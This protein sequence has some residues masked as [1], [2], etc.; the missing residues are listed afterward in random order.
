MSY[1]K[2]KSTKRFNFEISRNDTSHQAG[3]NEVTISTNPSSDRYSTGISTM[4]MT[5]KE[6]RALNLFLTNEL[7]QPSTGDMDFS[8]PNDSIVVS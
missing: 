7:A 5:V 1:T 8:D 4:R 2:S 3:S 6:A